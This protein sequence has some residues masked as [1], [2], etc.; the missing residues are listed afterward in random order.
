[1]TEKAEYRERALLFG[2]MS[3]GFGGFELVLPWLGGASSSDRLWIP[4]LLDV[5]G[6][7]FSLPAVHSRR[8]CADPKPGAPLAGLVFSLIAVALCGFVLFVAAAMSQHGPR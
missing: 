1:M 2:R 5:V 4:L 3:M 8:L 7:I 6:I